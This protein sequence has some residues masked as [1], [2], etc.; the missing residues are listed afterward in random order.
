MPSRKAV[1]F[2][3]PRGTFSELAARKYAPRAE[4][5]P[6]P[7]LRRLLEA[8][9]TGAVSEAVV[10]V[11][12][13]AEGAVG[14]ALDLLVHDFDL[15]IRGEVTV[16]VRHDLLARP[17]VQA[18]A[19]TTIFS[20]PQA[21]AQ[22]RN[23]L[24][25]RFPGVTVRE[26]ASTAEAADL[27]SRARGEPWAAIAS[28]RTCAANG[29]VPL[30]LNIQDHKNNA[31]RFLCVGRTERI[32][33]GAAAWKTSLALGLA[34]RPGALYRILREFALRGINL[35]RIES[36]PAKKKL[37][38]YLFFIDFQAHRLSPP[39]R[40]ALEALEGLT[41]WLKVLGSYPAARG[42]SAPPVR[43]TG[44]AA[45]RALI[46]VIDGEIVDLLARRCALAAATA[47]YK[48]D[49]RHPRD[50]AREGEVLARTERLAQEAGV[51]PDLVRAVYRLILE[52]TV[53][54]QTGKFA[55]W[56]YTENG[57]VL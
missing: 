12:N 19:V 36:R 47:K 34:D 49:P 28:V 52:H 23:Y 9:A 44:L 45:L 54:L 51:S 46:D 15:K 38:D 20:H 32:P 2:L 13:S 5:I 29:L 7:S 43:E 57:K 33:R 24:D 16:R 48:P 25:R 14:P 37:G 35:T 40:E 31:T 27:V 26:T 50:A 8:V 1:G 22:C 21:L 55:G 3:G 39:A 11:E 18:E 30:A 6:Y 17:G 53:E 41:T 4:L 42:G 10:P 56:L